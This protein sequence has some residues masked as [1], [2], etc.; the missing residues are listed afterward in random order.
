M[1]KF[2]SIKLALA[3]ACLAASSAQADTILG[4]YA[5]AQYWQVEP[6]GQFGS[7][8]DQQAAFNYDDDAQG[9]FYVALEHPVP[10]IPNIKIRQTQLEITG[11]KNMNFDFNGTAFDGNV[12]TEADLSNTDLTLYYEV[13]DNGL[14]SLDFGV[15]VK[16]LD[17]EIMVMDDDGTSRTQELSGYVPMGYLAAQVGLPLTGL[18]LYG[19]V[20]VLSIGDHSLTDYQAG[21][22]YAFVDNI[23]VDIS[24]QLG[25]RSFKLELD[26]L[27]GIHS[28]LEFSGA[29][30]GL[31]VHF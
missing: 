17:G 2:T 18:S 16:S 30:A 9:S 15:T 14:A 8:D 28:D 23:A 3:A 5:G 19:D 7:N 26:D 6:E 1:K 22:A 12:S 31:E 4:L 24:A 13:L 25:Y 29:Y 10:L 21:I 20:S 11:S 27:D